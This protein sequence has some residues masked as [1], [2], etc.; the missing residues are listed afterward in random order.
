VRRL[1][2]FAT[3]ALLGCAADKVTTI[4]P[5]AAAEPPLASGRRTVAGGEV[6]ALRG[7]SVT[8]ARV[9]YVNSPCPEGAKCLTSGIV[10][11][12]QFKVQHTVETEVT[13]NADSTQVVDGLELRVHDVRA[14][15]QADIEASLP[16]QR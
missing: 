12:V 2:L 3:L 4:A 14:G 1:G 15:P 9:M 6:I 11:Q 7:A 16:L 8:V 10:K 13:V 5:A